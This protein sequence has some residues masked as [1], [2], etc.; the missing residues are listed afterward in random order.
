M[1]HEEKTEAP[2]APRMTS[3]AEFPPPFSSSSTKPVMPSMPPLP[4]SMMGGTGTFHPDFMFCGACAD[5]QEPSDKVEL[6]PEEKLETYLDTEGDTSEFGN[7]ESTFRTKL[8]LREIISSPS[9]VLVI[10]SLL[11]PLPGVSKVHVNPTE[12]SVTVEHDASTST[13]SILVALDSVGHS[14]SIQAPI[15]E[16]EGGEPIWVRSQFYVQGICCTTEVPAV[17][18]IVKPMAGVSKLQIN[19]ATKMVHVQHDVNLI[20]AHQISQKLWREGFPAQIRRD[21]QV[22]VQAKQQALQTGRTTLTVTG[23][24]VEQDIPK[25]QSILSPVHGVSRIG[26]NVSEGTIH[27]DHD[28]FSVTSSGLSEALASAYPSSV[29]K[30]AEQS[31]EGEGGFTT[32]ELDQI[33]RSKFVEST[34]TVEGLNPRDV[35]RVEKEIAENF[36]RAQVRAI[37]PN[38]VSETIK[39]EHDP[40]LVSIL[41]IV[42]SLENIGLDAELTINGAVAGLYLPSQDDY[43]TVQNDPYSVEEFSLTKI[44]GN[45]WLSGIFWALSMVSYLDGK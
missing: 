12:P 42:R 38:V 26:V 25:I 39:V 8:H 16:K 22:T 15:E 31:I 11:Q 14:A 45:L 9:R 37:Y 44:H 24:L 28:L 3:A 21:G 36:I 1:M 41:D 10:Q 32:V 23:I 4:P 40:E 34:V 2:S 13:E 5:C 6:P 17:R 7:D 18:K 19:I 27:V 30:T 43:L 35:K 33:G 29:T 20:S